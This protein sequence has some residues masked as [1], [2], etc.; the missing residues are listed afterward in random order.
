MCGISG[1]N[2]KDE[3]LVKSMNN[4]M[5]HRG[6]DDEGCYIDKKISLGSVRLSIMD[7][8][9]KGHM[10][11]FSNDK[12]LIIIHNGEIYNFKEIRKELSKMGYRF[13]SKTDTEVILY[14]YKEWGPDCVKKFNGMWVFCIYDKEKNILFLSRDRFGIKPLYYY[15]KKGRFIFASEIKAILQH[16]VK[17]KA[18]DK[19]IFDF[20]FYDLVDHNE[21][22]FFEGI[23]RLPPGHNIIFDLEKRK[24][25]IKKYY[26]LKSRIKYIKNMKQQEKK[27]IKKIKKLFFDSVR[28][29][30]IADVPVGS[31]LSGGIDSSSIVCAMRK[32]N[33]N[34]KIKTFSLIFPKNK[35]IDESFYQNFVAK[36][37]NCEQHRTEI[38]PDDLLTD[39]NDLIYTQ[40][41]PFTG[42]S[43]Y[44]QY[45]VMEVAHKN[46]M[47]VLLDG[48]GSDEIF[49]GY[50]SFFIYYFEELIKKLK[51]MSFLKEFLLFYRKY[52]KP[53]PII[54]GL[55][56]FLPNSIRRYIKKNFVVF[57]L[58]EN[59]IRKKIC[60]EKEKKYWKSSVVLDKSIIYE[61]WSSLPTLLR[62]EDKNSM[63][64]SVE[65]RVPFCDH[66][67]VE[68]VLALPTNMKI[69]RGVTKYSFREAM[70]GILMEKIRKRKDKIGFAT[71]DDKILMES[72]MR[73][74]VSKLINSKKFRK[75]KYWDWKKINDMLK[76]HYGKKKDYSKEIWK[77]III[78]LWFEIW[79]EN[80]MK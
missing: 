40:E 76:K 14:S 55:L 7:L 30:L 2:W 1:F 10:P 59:F 29:R 21:E 73:E 77:I 4:A 27:A 12:K 36:K 11:M 78:E 19:I 5:K 58:R 74:A 53:Q 52:K 41:E 31:C 13:K 64:F 46:N 16:P 25:K 66:R 44:G 42:L 24:M 6:P 57:Y 45:K 54:I 47:K 37:N 75:R 56:S 61:T 22:T 9:L 51:I 18:N 72:A 79:I 32:I 8:S 39:L 43:V 63:R 20:L 60:Y 35:K 70:K 34:S 26:D 38:S 28:K 23:K 50:N 33:K 65:T 69:F 62:F 17:R 80:K 3:K 67:L 48:Q 71:P 49:C 15:F 68:Y